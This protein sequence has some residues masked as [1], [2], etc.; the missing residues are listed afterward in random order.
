MLDKN[1]VERVRMEGQVINGTVR[2]K[3]VIVKWIE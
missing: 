2:R 3:Y 1:I